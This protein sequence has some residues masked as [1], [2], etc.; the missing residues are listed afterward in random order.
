MSKRP[1]SATTT[2]DD[3]R[4]ELLRLARR[5]MVLDVDGYIELL[6][7]GEAVYGMSHDAN[8]SGEV[9]LRA[10]GDLCAKITRDNPGPPAVA[11]EPG[12][13]LLAL[14]QLVKAIDAGEALK[15]D[16]HGEGPALGQAR[17]AIANAHHAAAA[18]GEAK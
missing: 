9:A 5:V 7:D 17:R 3:E 2:L 14:K 6:V 4:A 18:A 11:S 12:E 13:P 16:E 10:F 8:T 1:A 15:S